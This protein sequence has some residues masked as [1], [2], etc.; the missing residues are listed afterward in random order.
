MREALQPRQ[1]LGG[2]DGR[3]PAVPEQDERRQHA[4]LP[5]PP[6][7]VSGLWATVSDVS[8]GGVCLA[9]NDRVLPGE[10]YEL[11][12]TDGLFP[13]TIEMQAEVVWARPGRAGLRWVEVTAEQEVW[14]QERFHAWLKEQE[15]L[16]RFNR[17]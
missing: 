5:D 15:F 7:F 1:A 12:L 13:F 2:Q 3:R 11:I 6:L 8:T 4:R 9:L 17:R 10:R 16:V 14:L